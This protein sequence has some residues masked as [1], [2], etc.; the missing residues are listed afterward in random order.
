MSTV[1]LLLIT[2]LGLGAL[3]FLV[4]AG[5]SLIY[6]LMGVLNFA[7]GAFLTAR[8]LRRLGGRAAG[9]APATGGSF[10]LVRCWSAPSSAPSFA[11]FDRVLPDP[12]A[13]PAAHRAG[14]GHRGPRTRR[15]GAL[16]RHLGHR[17]DVT[18]GPGLAQPDTTEILGAPIPNDR[19]LLHHRRR[20]W[21]C[22]RIVLFLQ[23]TRYGMIIRAGVE[24]R[25]M[26]TALGID[27]RRS[28]TLVF[29]IGGA[30]AG[31]GGVLASAL[32]RLRVAA[33]SGR[34]LL[35]FAF[36]VT[37]IGGLGSLTGA[38]IAAVARGGAAAVRQLLPRRHRR[39]RRGARPRARAAVPS[40]ADSSGERHDHR[41]DVAGRTLATPTPPGTRACGARH[42]SRRP[43]RRPRGPP[44]GG[45]A[46][47]SDA[48]RGPAAAAATCH[49][50]GV[51]PGPTY[52]PGT[53]QLLAMCMLIAALAL[54]YHL[55]LGVAGLLS[56]GHAL[57]FGAGVY[58][59]GDHPAEPGHARCC[60]RWA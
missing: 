56:F 49:S 27:V 53:L 13:V 28:F 3:Y 50:P 60:P 8:R 22:W 55:L 17:P 30:A 20:R 54:T 42:R 25:S 7:H 23:N 48:A 52:T 19:F 15:R 39:P 47:W 38:A 2:G 14:A 34:S 29:A 40:R 9:S 1:V 18:P 59:L 45:I 57:Y 58:G 41:T 24:N 46:G 12:P 32:L 35:I 16:R 5:L 4:A 37:V 21:C 36:I 51:L 26:V 11:A 44:I 31:L 10:L 33:R 43:V 6:G